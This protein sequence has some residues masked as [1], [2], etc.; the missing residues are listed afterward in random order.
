MGGVASSKLRSKLSSRLAAG[1]AITGALGV[2]AYVVLRPDQLGQGSASTVDEDRASRS[3]EAKLDATGEASRGVPSDPTSR[4]GLAADRSPARREWAH[5]LVMAASDGDANEVDLL[6]SKPPPG[7]S[8]GLV[9]IDSILPPGESYPNVTATYVAALK[10]EFHI[11]ETLLQAGADPNVKC[12]KSTQWD[13]AFTLTE[14]DTALVV[15]CKECHVQ[16]V[17][18]LLKTGA[19]P[20]IECNSEYFEGA[21]EWGEDDTGTEQF[22]YTALTVAER[23]TVGSD[24]IQSDLDHVLELLRKHD[25]RHAHKLAVKPSMRLSQGSRMGA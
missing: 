14:N 16:C 25:A 3:R 20:N 11:L 9:D 13:G 7:P 23:A 1:L 24:K 4:D 6:L 2:L 5:K 8:E 21:V 17:E 22:F 15:A 18:L 19:D 12:T 10:G